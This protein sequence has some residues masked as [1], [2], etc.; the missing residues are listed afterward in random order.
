AGILLDRRP[1]QEGRSARFAV[2]PR[3]IDRPLD[4]ANGGEIDSVFVGKM[5]AD[6]YGG[7]HGVERDADPLAF[8]VL[9]AADFGLA[10][11]EDIAMTKHPR[12]K[13][14]E[15]HEGTIAAGVAADVLG[16]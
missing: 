13:S 11:D 15:R 12:R 7:R 16:A 2:A 9:G 5:A 4:P 14:R 3:V 6:P 1:L 10:V 8:D